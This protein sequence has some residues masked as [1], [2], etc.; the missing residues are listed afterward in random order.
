MSLSF[1]IPSKSNSTTGSTRTIEWVMGNIRS[2]ARFDRL[3]ALHPKKP[4]VGETAAVCRK[5]EDRVNVGGGGGGQGTAATGGVTGSGDLC[6]DKAPSS[7][8]P[9]MLQ[10]V[11][12]QRGVHRSDACT[13]P[14]LPEDPRLQE[15]FR[16]IT[17]HT[18]IFTSKE[19]VRD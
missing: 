9:S 5:G 11:H 6:E 7:S 2:K 17:S 10:D 14:E 13:A 8:S 1:S 16:M 12:A 15:V 18:E 3:V 4:S 19:E